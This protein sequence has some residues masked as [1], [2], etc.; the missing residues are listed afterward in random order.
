M[1]RTRVYVTIDTEGAEE[2][3]VRGRKLPPQGYDLRV[4]GRFRNR[5][6]E[7]GVPLIARELEARGFRGTFYVEVFG[8]AFFGIEGLREVCGYLRDR[9][10]DVQLHTHPVQRNA[11]FRSKGDAPAPDDLAAY[12]VEAQ[13]SLLREGIA[14]LAK[15]GVPREDVVSLRAGNFGA[16]N[17][18]WE[19]MRRAGLVLSS[20]YNPCYWGK[21]SKMRSDAARA[22]LFEA[23]PDVWELPITNFTEP[24]GAFRH[25]QIT[26]V[27]TRETIDAMRA[28]RAMGVREITIVTHSF[29]LLHIDSV[30]ERTGRPNTLNVHRFRELL[31]FLR[32][33]DREFEVDTCGAL[34]KRLARGEERADPG[35]PRDLPR[36]SSGAR[37]VRLVEQAYKR[38]EARI[39]L[40]PP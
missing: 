16:S 25:L 26:A 23:L 27:S 5:H 8:S 40:A 20:N 21:R 34:G 9:G 35:C 12:D 1:D 24:R 39:P 13:A 38:L 31:R 18:T 2:R 3:V 19:A 30:A 29:E 36:G 6:D 33:N 22:G 32:E 15:C 37:A 14:I 10:H 11:A 4:W 17:E 7:L 28:A